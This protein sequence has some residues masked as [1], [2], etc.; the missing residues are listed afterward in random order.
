VSFHRRN[1]PH[2]QRDYRPHFIT[3]CTKERRILPNWARQIVLDCCTHGHGTIYNLHVAVV[4]PDHA[5]IILTPLEDR[6]RMMISSLPEIMK[7]I[8]GTA[9]HAINRRLKRRGAVWLEESFDHV[10]RSSE[11]LDAKIAYI[12]ANPIRKGLVS[13]PSEYS[14]L[15]V[16]SNPK[17][18]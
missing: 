2:I 13:L 12:V 17:T 7:A 16:R 8:K 14:W 10:V 9:A 15:W 18:V 4:M 3:F 1:L 11:S 5:H 6:D